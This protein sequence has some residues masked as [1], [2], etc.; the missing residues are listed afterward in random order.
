ML[1]APITHMST[2]DY[3]GKLSAV[4]F[5]GGCNLRCPYCQN[6]SLISGDDCTER[7]E[8]DVLAELR[9][10]ADFLDAVTITGGEP[11]LQDMLPLVMGIKEMGLLVK[12][13]TNGTHPDK[14]K[15][16]IDLVDYVAIDVKAPLVQDRY[17]RIIGR[18]YLDIVEL[19]R[20]SKDIARGKYLE[21]RTTVLPRLHT[22]EDLLD[23]ARTIRADRLTIQQFRGS[24][25]T[26]DPKYTNEPSYSRDELVDIARDVAG[27]FENYV[28]I[29]TAENGLERVTPTGVVR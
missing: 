20:R 6:R 2:V 3:P 12:I 26:L 10:S 14:L 28:Y 18:E 9:G 1:L 27:V 11:L 23:I 8:E 16:L 21:A 29:R 5:L 17:E 13:D 24:E 4:V 15:A 7:S 25:G 19:V 22:R